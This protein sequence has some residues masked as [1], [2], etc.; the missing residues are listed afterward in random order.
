MMVGLRR[1]TGLI[2]LRT[3]LLLLLV[4][5]AG[6][7]V[8]LEL[9]SLE[10]PV[11]IAGA[12]RFHPGDDPAWARPDFD[13]E[14]WAEIEVPV[15]WGRQGYPDVG[16]AWY[17]RTVRLRLSDEALDDLRLAVSLGAVAS[18]YELYAGGRLLGGAGALPPRPRLAY[19]QQR[20]LP[21]PRRALAADGRLVLA[22]R[23]YRAPEHGAS[24]GGPTSGNFLLGP[25]EVLTEHA[26]RHR[27]PQLILTWL[28]L[29]VGLFHLNLYRRRPQQRVYLW[30]GLFALNNAAFIFLRSQ[31]RFALGDDFALLKEAEY[32]A[33]FLLPVLAIQFFWT[34]FDKPIG[35]WLRAYQ[36]SHVALAVVV[37]TPGLGLNLLAVRWWEL[38]VA[39]LL[40]FCLGMIL[41]RAL[42]GDPDARTIA[43]G[44]V[45]LGLTFAS[46]ILAGRG[47]VNLPFLSAYGFAACVLSMA[48]SL[49]NRFSRVHQQ[50]DALRQ[51]LEARVEQRT[52]QLAAAK[53]AAEAANRAKSEF[54]ANM[55]HEI[56]TPMTSIIGM[57]EL[58]G[59]DGLTPAQEHCLKTITTSADALLRLVDDILDFSR[60]EAGGMTL[61]R[62]R[63]RPA[64]LV[65][66]V[67]RLLEPSAEVKGLVLSVELAADLPPWVEGDPNRLRQVLINLVG[68]AIKFTD[69]G[70][71]RIAASRLAA[72]DG[73][74]RFVV[75]DTGIGIEPRVQEALFDPFTQ[76]DGSASRRF[77]GTGLGL[78]ISRRIVELAGGRIGVDS[79]VGEGSTFWLE[80]PLPP[81]A[82]PPEEAPQPPAPLWTP[83]DPRPQPRVL[84]A[85]D[86]PVNQL[87]TVRQ[88]ESLGCRPTAVE[89]GR[90]VLDALDEHR[91]DLVLMDCQMPELDGYEA[92]RS[93]RRREVDGQHL[94]VIALTAH[95][96][97][98]HRQ[99]CFEAGMDDFL[100]KP[101]HIAEL[102]TILARWLPPRSVVAVPARGS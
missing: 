85:E 55:S 56:R 41:L 25:I 68:N 43:V 7:A 77:G 54:L 101:F 89:N 58:L 79:V 52:H 83:E 23:V 95:A 27:L 18:S 71:V 2:T 88:L 59:K 49:A 1:E 93:L 74:L 33:R 30:F 6:G 22:L 92:T 63:F 65:D 80:V 102:A 82:A 50:L 24:A 34:L 13:D 36:L 51:D 69:R 15:P 64:A 45:V 26:I 97:P 70:R 86:N 20:I 17:R 38:W 39:P 48:T 99:R 73:W 87:L 84:L 62:E 96:L 47:V 57:A 91:F 16:M 94:P 100:A 9:D 37:A 66:D 40:A 14:D 75:E 28:F 81:V 67:V 12:W 5:T 44:A 31:W 76:A 3:H 35:R 98:E 46:D 42:R 53:S 8:P 4:A 72:E 78:A 32:V 61:E 21:I 19:D 60:I 90:Q 11:S 10:Q 29:A